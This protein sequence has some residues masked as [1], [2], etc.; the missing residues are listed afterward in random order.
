[1]EREGIN[2]TLNIVA[3]T[4]DN[5]IVVSLPNNI[6]RKSGEMRYHLKILLEV[7]TPG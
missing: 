1:M 3:R 5:D 6:L 4:K 7:K 2:A